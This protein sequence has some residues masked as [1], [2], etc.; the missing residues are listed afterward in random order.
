MGPPNVALVTPSSLSPLLH[1]RIA[2]LI[3]GPGW[4]RTL[5]LRRAASGGLVV[6]ALVTALAPAPGSARAPVVVAAADLAGGRTIHAADLALR[7]WPPD[8]I[9]AGSVRDPTTVDGRVLVGAARAGEPLTDVRLVGGGLLPSGQDA[10]VPVR[11]GDAAVAA[12][13]VPGRRVD[14]VTVGERSDRPILLAEDAVVLAVL[15]EDARVRGRLVIVSMPRDI[16]ARVAS[17][18]LTDQVAVTLRA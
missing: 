9:P 12:L 2:A 13:L 16:A 14:V 1:H 17:A 11:L 5:L 4:R 7:H 6:L 10:A 3:G 18:S 8:L 15:A